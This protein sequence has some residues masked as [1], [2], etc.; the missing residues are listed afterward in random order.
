MSSTATMRERHRDLRGGTCTTG[1]AHRT[2][3]RTRPRTRPRATSRRTSRRRRVGLPGRGDPEVPA[4]VRPARSPGPCPGPGRAAPAR[5]PRPSH[6]ITPTAPCRLADTLRQVTPA[7]RRRV[8]FQDA[9]SEIARSPGRTEVSSGPEEELAR[10]SRCAAPVAPRRGPRGP[11]ARRRVEFWGGGCAG[12]S[13]PR[14]P[15]GRRSQK[16]PEV[17]E[18][19]RQRQPR[20]GAGAIEGKA[21]RG[22]A[23][24]GKSRARAHSSAWSSRRSSIACIMAAMTVGATVMAG[25]THV[26]SSSSGPSRGLRGQAPNRRVVHFYA[27]APIH[28]QTAVDTGCSHH[29]RYDRRNGHRAG[30]RP[31]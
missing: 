10:T 29:V 20:I 7:R 3:S 2:T 23:P 8:V 17:A 19:R 26:A 14:E 22:D 24:R 18:G 9:G 31:T 1:A 27:A 16:I 13:R 6:K 15:R 21:S 11:G 4:E 12:V 30:T 5:P 28:N 25:V